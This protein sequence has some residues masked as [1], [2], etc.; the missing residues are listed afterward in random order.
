MAEDIPLRSNVIQWQKTTLNRTDHAR[1]MGQKPAVLWFTGLSASGK[2]TIA[3]LVQ[4]RLHAA[5]IKTFL[6]DGDNLRHG[7]S[8]DL[9][10]SASDRVENMRRV[11]EVARLMSDAGLIVLVAFISPFGSERE[12]ARA[13]MADGE[14]IEI[15]VDTSFEE[16]AR[17]DPKGLYRRALAGELSNFTGLDSPYE[18]PSSPDI[19]LKTALTGAEALADEVVDHLKNRGLVPHG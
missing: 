11:S 8:S 18:A 16:C 7:L 12:A 14:F 9:G 2:S 5:G 10:F 3:N 6:L 4:V 13:R 17:R 19:H 15:F 1:L